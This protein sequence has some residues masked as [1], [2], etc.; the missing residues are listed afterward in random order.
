[1]SKDYYVYLLTNQR[2]N[3]LYTGITNNLVRRVYEHKNKQVSGFTKKYNVNRL[4]Y[5]EIYSD[6]RDA[7]DKEK[8]IKGCSR[9]KKDNLVI[10]FNPAWNDLY[11]SIL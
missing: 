6:V 8:E 7:V 4:V 3:V 1:M 9:T 2:L 5:Y 10:Q 11:E